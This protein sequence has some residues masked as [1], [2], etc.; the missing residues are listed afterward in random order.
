[1]GGAA[2]ST[3]GKPK[4]NIVP[5]PTPQPEQHPEPRE[6]GTAAAA[7]AQALEA[8]ASIA[9]TRASELEKDPHKPKELL[10][11]CVAL[12]ASAE[13]WKAQLVSEA[14]AILI[15][16]GDSGVGKTCVLMQFTDETF[17]PVHS[18]TV[19]VEFGSK[20][21][22]VQEQKVK[23]QIWDTVSRAGQENF[24]N[25]TRSYYRSSV[26]ALLVYDISRRSSFDN[27]SG[28]LGELRSNCQPGTILVLVGNKCDLEETRTVTKDEGSRFAA[29]NGLMFFESSA[30]TAHNVPEMFMQVVDRFVALRSKA[31]Q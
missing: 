20:V 1:M 17:S 13:A 12:K 2:S 3:K 21:V 27:L 6:I 31:Q 25:I 26:A 11:A 30:K 5:V 28:W 7:A 8:L 19:G 24:R 18:P 16:V 15:L 23:L 29:D 10:Q 14:A 4:P 22:T 9:A